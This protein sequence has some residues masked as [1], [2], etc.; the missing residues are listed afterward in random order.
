[1]YKLNEIAIAQRIVGA[2]VLPANGPEFLKVLDILRAL[3]ARS[4]GFGPSARA[5]RA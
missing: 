4:P 3:M 5:F 1:M 2:L